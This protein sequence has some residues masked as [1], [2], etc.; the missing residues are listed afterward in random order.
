[1]SPFD[2]TIYSGLY[3]DL[4]I[5]ALFT[6]EAEIAA[7]IRFEATLAC[8]Q[9]ALKVIPDSDLPR[10]LKSTT[11]TPSE[12]RKGVAGSGIPVPALVAAL[13]AQI[14]ETAQHLHW[15]ATTQDVMDTAL[16]LR[17][18]DALVIMERRLNAIIKRL[19]K[20]ADEHRNSVQA[21]R[22]WM[23]H[24]T[25]TSFGLKCAT[26]LDPILRQKERL[27]QLRPRILCVQ[28]GGASGT[29]AATP[30]GM[31]TMRTIA[32]ELGLAP[33]TPWHSTRDRILELAGWLSTIT[34]TL[35][36][37]GADL[38]I[39]AQTEIA[40]VALGSTG[41]SST[42]PQKQNPVGPSALV[43]LARSN[44]STIGELHHAALQT[45]ERDVA[46]W[47]AEWSALPRMVCTTGAALKI[48]QET[49]EDLEPNTQRMREN[50]DLTDGAILAETASFALAEFMPRAEAQ[51]MVKAASREDEPLIDALKKQ[52]DAR[53]DWENLNDPSL[54]TGQANQ[55]IDAILARVPDE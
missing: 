18:R 7:M 28:F 19:A 14:G 12:L 33:T 2:S 48:A 23:Q 8:A 17:L 6:D 31:E 29:L 35:G 16:V 32:A 39:L 25:P 45:M 47:S 50:L 24:S 11:V 46:H 4:E 34:S 3:S 20:L 42:M 5:T 41:G 49:L 37:L 52:T 13:R 40:E 36:K 30:L 9:I 10:Q 1:M 55:I 15:G 27:A 43:T 38:I 22:T 21:G 26:S 54:Q 53:V 44:A 51:A